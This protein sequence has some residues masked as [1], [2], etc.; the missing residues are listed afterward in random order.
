MSNKAP[1]LFMRFLWA[2]SATVSLPLA[3]CNWLPQRKPSPPGDRPLTV[4]REI[5]IS[6]GLEPNARLERG[7]TMIAGYVT[8]AN[9][10]ATVPLALHVEDLESGLAATYFSSEFTTGQ[11]AGQSM[12][13]PETGEF[14]IDCTA[15]LRIGEGAK[16]VQIIA[17]G[18]EGEQA[19]IEVPVEATSQ[20]P[21]FSW[22]RIIAARAE[23]GTRMLSLLHSYSEWIES[24]QF[25][26]AHFPYLERDRAILT[27]LINYYVQW[28]QHPRRDSWQQAKQTLEQQ[29]QML[30]EHWPD[31]D[32][33]W[34]ELWGGLEVTLESHKSLVHREAMLNLRP[35]HYPSG[36]DHPG[37]WQ[38]YEDA[39]LHTY[40]ATATSSSGPVQRW[41]GVIY[42]DEGTPHLLYVDPHYQSQVVP[43]SG[44]PGHPAA[45][46]TVRAIDTNSDGAVDQLEWEA[47][48]NFGPGIGPGI[49]DRHPGIGPHPHQGAA[50][51]LNEPLAALGLSYWWE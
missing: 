30:Q 15:D 50:A 44:D 26:P 39:Y 12:V 14:V 21:G 3:G 46:L 10:D 9:L 33:A 32:E 16:R 23:Y 11:S 34:E 8:P 31:P 28:H 5:V 48:V 41:E 6:S 36:V 49:Q 19:L 43:G 17:Y 1:L 27:A 20:F 40:A 18:V 51:H 45:L 24:L 29:L 7:E 38:M 42:A 22:E 47:L 25:D 37:I 2:L 35:A 13:N 4:Q